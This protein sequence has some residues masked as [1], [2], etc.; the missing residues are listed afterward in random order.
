MKHLLI[1]PGLVPMATGSYAQTFTLKSN[2]LGGQATARQ[3][4]NGNGCAGGNVSPQLAW[5]NA[6][7]GTQSFAV[8]MYDKDAPTG[9]G[10]WHWVVFNLPASATELKAG[11]GDGSKALAPQGSVQSLT[12]FGKPGYSGPCPP[13][14]LARQYLITVYALG[15]RLELDKTATPALVGFYLGQAA[16]ARASLIIYG[17]R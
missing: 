9:S 13:P 10:W 17:Q 2:E 6:P 4:L 16:L 14:G 15:S 11:A 5:E 3:F 12:D 8:T 7:K 1:P